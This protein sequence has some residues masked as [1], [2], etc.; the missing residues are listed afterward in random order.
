MLK[1]KNKRGSILIFVLWTVAL[2]SVLVATLAANIRLSAQTAIHQSD[3]I[4]HR[5]NVV[6]VLEMAKME[7]LFSRFSGQMVASNDIEGRL[8]KYRFHGKQEK[9]FYSIPETT[10]V[11]IYDHSGKINLTRLVPS[12]MTELLTKQLTLDDQDLDPERL[13]ALLSAWQD[14]VD[15]DDLI[16]VKGAEAEYYQTL[17]PPYSPR[18]GFMQT[19][20][21]L[22]QI[23][24]YRELFG[25]LNM[26]S[27]FTV[28]GF[29]PKVNF[30]LA[31]RDVLKLIPGL[32]P[33]EVEAIIQRR[34]EVEMTGAE[35]AF[36]VDADHIEKVRLW[37][38]TNNQ[39]SNYYTIA[40][41]KKKDQS[42]D[43]D[44]Y[45]YMED[46]FIEKLNEVPRTLRV[47]PY[48]KLPIK[49]VDIE[50]EES[51]E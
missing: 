39:V 27:I 8:K 35:L 15:L 4:Q 28:Y 30:N 41:Q 49:P 2:I 47:N 16:K 22:L 36:I 48:G 18:N 45:A 46:V 9:L 32:T 10:Q 29:N 1:L 44:E 50:K 5:A 7:L 37:M 25:H 26:H 31:N 51:E 17:E 19:V 11:Y 43:E 34:K 13:T 24:G 20:E 14:W 6:S 12:L 38:D 21:E 40:V 42:D 23:R 3:G 33:Q